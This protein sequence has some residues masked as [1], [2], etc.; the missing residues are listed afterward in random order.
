MNYCFRTGKLGRVFVFPISA[1]IVRA[2]AK[3]SAE[4]GF[5]SC[6]LARIKSAAFVVCFYSKYEIYDFIHST[7]L[8]A[9]FF[10]MIN[11][12]Q[13]MDF[14]KLNMKKCVAFFV[15]KCC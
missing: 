6:W 8:T 5:Q 3:Q 15:S 1:S 9:H 11:R 14:S 7:F 2:G 10:I 12:M 13:R 4:N